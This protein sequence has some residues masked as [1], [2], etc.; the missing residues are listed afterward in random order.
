MRGVISDSDFIYIEGT[1]PAHASHHQSDPQSV[2]INNK[3][4]LTPDGTRQ[5]AMVTH[6]P[7]KNI[8]KN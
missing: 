7:V 5:H 3:T 8:Y 1:Q 2:T 4:T 6:G